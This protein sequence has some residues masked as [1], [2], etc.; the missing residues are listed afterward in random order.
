MVV[1]AWFLR[2]HLSDDQGYG[3]VFSVGAYPSLVA[4]TSPADLLRS[5][6]ISRLQTVGKVGNNFLKL[7]HASEYFAPQQLRGAP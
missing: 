5:E 4:P 7:Q 6:C 3:T 1:P 2:A